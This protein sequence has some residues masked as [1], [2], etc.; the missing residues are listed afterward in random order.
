MDINTLVISRGKIEKGSGTLV[1]L[2]N[3][4]KWENSTLVISGEGD[5]KGNGTLDVLR[6]K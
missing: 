2:G 5:R 4:R 1:L 3:E 6:E